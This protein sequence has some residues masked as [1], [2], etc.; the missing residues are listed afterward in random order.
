MFSNE[1]VNKSQSE[2]VISQEQKKTQHYITLH[3][4]FV[5]LHMMNHLYTCRNYCAITI[6][7]KKLKLPYK[8]MCVMFS[9]ILLT[10]ILREFGLS[11]FCYEKKQ[12]IYVRMIGKIRYRTKTT[13]HR[14]LLSFLLPSRHSVT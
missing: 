1:L 12:I 10:R 13:R 14:L 5:I 2:K 8:S 4:N 3:H 11:F 7:Y 6:E 9:G